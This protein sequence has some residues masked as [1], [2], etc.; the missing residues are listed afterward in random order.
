MSVACPPCFVPALFYAFLFSFIA[1]FQT[2]HFLEGKSEFLSVRAMS[3]RPPA[4]SYSLRFSKES[5]HTA[6]WNVTTSL[7]RHWGGSLI[8][9]VLWALGGHILRRSCCSSQFRGGGGRF[10]PGAISLF[11][12]EGG[13]SSRFSARQRFHGARAGTRW[14]W[15]RCACGVAAA[16]FLRPFVATGKQEG[17][18]GRWSHEQSAERP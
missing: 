9:G 10:Q 3:D 16:D 1:N 8:T 18:L 6:S 2:A 17:P 12:Q 15:S 7:L 4:P 13:H 11:V 5:I 14:L